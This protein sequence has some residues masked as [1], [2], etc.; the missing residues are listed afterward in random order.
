[1]KSTYTKYA[2][3]PNYARLTGR[4]AAQL[5]LM[6]HG[7]TGVNIRYIEGDAL[8]NYFDPRSNEIVLSR[9]VY[10][11][12][13]VSAIGIAAHEAGHAVQYA[14]S[15]APMKVRAAIIP[16]T[17]IGSNLAFPLVLLGIIFSFYP[18]TYACLLYTS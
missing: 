3:Q 18:L 5:V 16:V 17:Q 13:S 12:S 4:E 10:D 8:T 11:S 15:Y 1:M 9:S 6:Q 14:Q 7:I 2:S